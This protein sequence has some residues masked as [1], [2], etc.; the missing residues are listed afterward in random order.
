[1]KVHVVY[2]NENGNIEFTKEELE[3]LLDQVYEEGKADA[4][5]MFNTKEIHINSIPTD[6]YQ[7]Y[8]NSSTLNHPPY[9]NYVTCKN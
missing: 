3:Q 9:Y 4:I 5:K 1:M 2:P 8:S 6:F 7:Y